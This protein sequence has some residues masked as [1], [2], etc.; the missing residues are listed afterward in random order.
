MYQTDDEPELIK[1]E[2]QR[3]TTL[4]KREMHK[5]SNYIAF[6]V[7]FKYLI[8]QPDDEGDWAL[9]LQQK[10]QSLMSSPMTS[11]AGT[12]SYVT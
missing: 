3:V 6:E 4:V 5:G 11:P 12:D 1:E 8:H 10:Q 9:Y 2:R 7:Y